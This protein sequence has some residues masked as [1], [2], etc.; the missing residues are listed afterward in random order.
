MDN[1]AVASVLNTGACRDRALQNVLREIA[2]IAAT[3]QFVIKA[4]HISGVS[5]RVPD[6]LSRWDENTARTQFRQHAKDGSLKYIRTTAK[7]LELNNEW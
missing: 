2:L 6:W 3:H 4:R 7:L 1:E 5:N